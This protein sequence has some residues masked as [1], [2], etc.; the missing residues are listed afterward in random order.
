MHKWVSKAGL[1]AKESK[2]GQVE[3]LPLTPLKRAEVNLPRDGSSNKRRRLSAPKMPEE[4][5][6]DVSPDISSDAL[7]S[8]LNQLHNIP[9]SDE[10]VT[11]VHVQAP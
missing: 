2:V 8:T 6:V 5:D 11:R 9:P 10:G 1:D 7:A 3:A 4:I